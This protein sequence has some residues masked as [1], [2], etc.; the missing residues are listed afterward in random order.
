MESPLLS[1]S[2]TGVALRW[3]P[4]GRGAGAGGVPVGA[5]CAAACART[6]LMDSAVS[7]SSSMPVAI[8]AQDDHTI[9]PAA[10]VP[11]IGAASLPAAA[12]EAAAGSAAGS[13]TWAMSAGAFRSSTPRSV[14]MAMSSRICCGTAL[15]ASSSSSTDG[16]VTEGPRP[17]A[18]STAI[19]TASSLYTTCA[20]S[21]I[22]CAFISRFARVSRLPTGPSSMTVKERNSSASL[23]GMSTAAASSPAVHAGPLCMKRMKW[24]WSF[25]APT[26]SCVAVPG[27]TSFSVTPYMRT[28][29]STHCSMMLR[30]A[31]AASSPMRTASRSP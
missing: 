10:S 14:S 1:N 2:E 4:C 29:A 23:P 7:V 11:G 16:N 3:T 15:N 5:G 22:W 18:T 26:F 9:A 24:H 27:A 28:S 12:S 17:W 8:T 19:R 31:N 25:S 13:R 6:A 20:R 21:R 30:G